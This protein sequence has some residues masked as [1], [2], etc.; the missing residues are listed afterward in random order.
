MAQGTVLSPVLFLAHITDIHVGASS[1]VSNFADEIRIMRDIRGNNDAALLQLDLDKIYRWSSSNNM[2]F[3]DDKFQALHY[4]VGG[5]T[6]H[7]RSY[8]APGG[9]VIEAA[10]EV[11]GLRVVIVVTANLR[12]TLRRPLEKPEI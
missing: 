5:S 11:K 1:T 3:N 10:K 7:Q 2:N 9:R 6:L 12:R 8:C 4:N